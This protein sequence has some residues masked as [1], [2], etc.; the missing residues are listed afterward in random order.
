MVGPPNNEKIDFLAPPLGSWCL[1]L[2]E[3]D[4]THMGPRGDGQ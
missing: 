1:A 2:R 4:T 3:R